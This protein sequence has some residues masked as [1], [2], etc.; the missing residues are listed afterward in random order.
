[1][2]LGLDSLLLSGANEF[3]LLLLCHSR[4]PKEGLITKGIQVPF[5]REGVDIANKLK[6]TFF[7]ILSDIMK[8]ADLPNH[9]AVLIVHPNRKDLGA[10]LFSELGEAPSMHRFINQAVLDI[11]TVRNLIAWA[12]IPYHESRIAVISFHIAPHAAQNAMLKILEEPRQGIRFVLVTSNIESLLETVISRTMLVRY[13]Q[14]ERNLSLALR[15][16][17]E[18]PSARMKLKGVAE[19]LAG[20]DEEGRKDRESVRAFILSLAE[21][22]A[23]EKKIP[24]KYVKETLAM[25][26]YAGDPSV[27]VKFI[28]EYL[29][30]LLPKCD[31]IS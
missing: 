29:S 31:I 1:M 26:S 15:F 23:K 7:A 4:S 19:L 30:L 28:I 6:I 21:A 16:L 18:M 10:S 20:E 3:F 11:E 14:E 13:D 5:Y 2:F 9:H 22:L 27:T 12:N 24:K 25:A 8:L 17:K